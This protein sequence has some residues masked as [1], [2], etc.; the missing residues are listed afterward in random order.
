MESPEDTKAR[1]IAHINAILATRAAPTY[2]VLGM[3]NYD[4]DTAI[5]NGPIFA[6]SYTTT[7]EFIEHAQRI[8]DKFD[9]LDVHSPEP[10]VKFA[11]K[12]D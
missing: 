10:L 9:P 4:Q 6:L 2:S 1:L 5:I 7:D 3:T 8:V 11:G 12:L